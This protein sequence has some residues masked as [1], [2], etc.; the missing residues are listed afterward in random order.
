MHER[1]IISVEDHTVE[2]PDVWTSRLA[3][4][5]QERGPRLAHLAH[6]DGCAF[7]DRLEPWVGTI[8]SMG[9]DPTEVEYF[10]LRRRPSRVHHLGGRVERYWRE[11]R[12]M[13]LAPIAQEMILNY[14]AEQMLGLTH[15]Y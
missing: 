10:G 6:G 13:R 7:E 8:C 5:Y 1:T 2:D 9:T 4:K 14:L 11:A 3:K 15:S 12:L